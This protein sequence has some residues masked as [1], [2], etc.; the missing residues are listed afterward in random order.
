[1]TSLKRARGDAA[2]TLARHWLESKGYTT[3]ETNFTRRVGEI[4]LIMQ[5]PNTGPIVFVEVRFR[6]NQSH[7]G[8]VASVNYRKQQKLRR[9][10]Q[11]WLQRHAT[12][13]T[14]A[15]IDVIAV[16]PA[17]SGYQCSEH[18]HGHQMTWIVNAVEA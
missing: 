13:R 15:R 8:G 17:P 3:I 12:S 6:K 5:A 4:D 7:G 1:M 9:T 11:A 16:A 10:A 14:E 18:W 2:E